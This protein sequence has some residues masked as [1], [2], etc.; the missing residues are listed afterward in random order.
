MTIRLFLEREIQLIR[1]SLIGMGKK[2]DISLQ[3][4]FQSYD[5]K[6]RFAITASYNYIDSQFV[7]NGKT[8]RRI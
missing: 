8:F 4:A 6:H 1:Q 5:E 3:T 7:F 2:I